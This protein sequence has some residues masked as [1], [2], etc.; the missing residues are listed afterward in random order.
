MP[1]ST[2]LEQFRIADFVAWDAEGLLTLN[3]EFQRGSVWTA[4]A[5]IYLIDTILRQL[6]IPKIYLRTHIDL[7]TKRST[8]DVVDGQQRLRA[9]LDFANGKIKLS[10]RAVEFS[11]LRYRD[12]DPDLQARFLSY[13]ISVD[14][15][16]NA[17]NADVLEVF[18]RLNSYTV[19]LNAAERRHAMF[20]GD[21]KN[22]ARGYSSKWSILWEDYHILST[23]ECVR[24]QNDALFAELFDVVMHGVQDFSQANLTKLYKD[25]DKQFVDKERVCNIVDETLTFIIDNLGE[26][27]SGDSPL[28]RSPQFLILFAATAH[29]LF[30]IPQGE[31]PTLPSRENILTDTAGAVA[32][33]SALNGILESDAPP[34]EG[35][36][37]FA[38]FYAAA[39]STT[40][41]IASRRIRFDVIFDALRDDV[42]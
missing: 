23:R 17:T 29:A 3:P 22:T 6:P 21:F 39:K 19:V 28:S 1:A 38:D 13:P 10:S 8:R 27:I 15:L 14:Q 24:M 33:L 40:Q 11:G 25:N 4:A 7:V 30:G 37:E 16:I 32:K 5:R 26:A 42:A 12:L 2:I 9:I 35:L 20:S 18:A 34:T 31:L 41:R 36:S